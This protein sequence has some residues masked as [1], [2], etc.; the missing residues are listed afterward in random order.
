MAFEKWLN[1]VYHQ[2]KHSSTGESPFKRFTS[3]MECI[4][5]AP[6]DLKDHFRKTEP[7]PLTAICLKRRL[8]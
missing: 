5:T 6:P 7:S 2:R 8:P 3:A 1:D 4:R